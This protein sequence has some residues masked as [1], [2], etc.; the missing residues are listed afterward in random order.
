MRGD[1]GFIF[2]DASHGTAGGV[3]A[4]G[5]AASQL[6]FATLCWH[7]ACLGPTSTF[8]GTHGRGILWRR[9]HTH[10]TIVPLKW[11]GWG[12]LG[13]QFFGNRQSSFLTRKMPSSRQSRYLF[14]NALS[15]ARVSQCA[16]LSHF[17]SSDP[18]YSHVLIKR[19]TFFYF[20]TLLLIKV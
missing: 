10:Y 16:F 1:G 20:Q 9:C 11:P 8:S 14:G 19:L 13:N 5:Q 12:T 7:P 17:E 15:T 2:W 4:D 3:K 6:A 18:R